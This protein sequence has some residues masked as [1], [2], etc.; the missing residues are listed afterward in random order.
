M[1]N[2]FLLTILALLP[3]QVFAHADHAPK[4]AEC[5]QKECVKEEIEKSVP[6]AVKRLIKSGKVAATWENAKVEGVELKSFK[7]NEEWVA[8][9]S[10]ESAAD[11]S[12]AK[13]YV[14]ITKKGQLNGSNFD[15]K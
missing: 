13:L 8:T 14:Y 10:D 6:A 9:V 3:A 7:K 15:G 12:K 1:K 4:V 11:A 2:L 5:A